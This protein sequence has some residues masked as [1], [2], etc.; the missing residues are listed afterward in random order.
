M[1][2]YIIF[3]F[4]LFIIILA[5]PL[6]LAA[7]ETV[8]Q[9]IAHLE[10]Q[11]QTASGKEKAD[12]LNDLAYLL[13][14]QSPEKCIKYAREALALAQTLD[15][16]EGE[17]LAYNNI[18][19]GYA[20]NGHYKEA[21]DNFNRALP[22]FRRT[23][24]SEGVSRTLNNQGNVYTA[25]SDY[26]DALDAYKQSLEIA[27]KA[28][29]KKRIAIARG[30]LGNLFAKLSQFEDSLEH[31]LEALKL[32][33]KLGDRFRVALTS[34]NIGRLHLNMGNYPQAQTYLEKAL[35][36]YRE[37]GAMARVCDTL[38][39]IGYLYMIR[40]KFPMALEYLQKAMAKSK[41]AG[42]T[43][44]AAAALDG[45]GGVYREMKDYQ[46]A[47]VHFKQSL[48]LYEQIN[49]KKT[50][51][52]TLEHIGTVYLESNQ[53]RL[54]L[55]YFQRALRIEEELEDKKK[56]IT[57]R[58]AV[59][60]TYIQLRDFAAAA[61]VLEQSLR[62]AIEI[63]SKHRT[64]ECYLAL[65]AL[66]TAKGDFKNALHFHKLYHKTDREI[67]NESS[68]SR[69]NRLQAKYEAEKK[70]KE[71]AI[72]EQEKKISQLELGRARMTRNT[73]IAGF[74][75]VLAILATL[76][77]KYLYLFSFWKKQSYVGRFRLM[78]KVGAGAMGSVYK[79]HNL[80]DKSDIAAVKILRDELFGDTNSKIR[81]KR[82]AAIIDKLDHP[83]IIRI[84]EVGLARDK[85][86]IAM[87]FLAGR[88]LER[89]IEEESLL[90]FPRC[91][92]LMRQIAAAVEYIHRSKIIHRDLKP[93]N[94]MLIE[95]NN[96]PDFV[97]LLDFGLARTEFHT[98]LTQSGN[99]VGTLEYMA[100]EQVLDGL[101]APANDIFSM[102]VIF[103]YLLSGRKPFAGETVLEI[104]KLLV[105]AEPPP[106][107][108]LRPETPRDLEKLITAM[109]SKEFT[110]RPTAT[111]VTTILKQ[112]NP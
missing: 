56:I 65:T 109:I 23:G 82:E 85:L 35:A 68:S 11:L 77:R 63:K 27:R 19:T 17:A 8:D 15:Y 103:Y 72:L 62:M 99:F 36:A 74:I 12:L 52:L 28:D 71:I 57:A 83:N 106:L 108:Q 58:I 69:V 9:K 6:F 84:Y 75:L 30:N 37:T 96:D 81:F 1:K 53:P 67:L 46:N 92:H 61:A 78:D 54:A 5:C 107:S 59:S 25:K 2:R 100:P 105:T 112:I 95:E 31:H 73:F 33:E 50:I 16:P 90:P 10:Q 34:A 87:E 98:R 3:L 29:L 76:F 104:M 86:F 44:G 18:A 22:I 91:L 24:N 14:P 79:A 101:S 20:V 41:K 45:I 70:E 51:S 4:F 80:M 48:A 60:K 97:K 43:R 42:Y 66:Y 13:Y 88:T 64:K 7:G 39:S 110:Q 26:D 93:G 102:G 21:L 94:I 38:T 89:V 111:T 55:S 32:H 40:G 47:L 49:F